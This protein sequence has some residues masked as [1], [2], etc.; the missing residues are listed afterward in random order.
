MYLLSLV[1]L[2]F[3]IQVDVISC[4]ACHALKP[5]YWLAGIR[6]PINQGPVTYGQVV[7][8]LPFGNVITI[9]QCT[10]QQV[11]DALTRSASNLGGGA[12]LQVSG[13]RFFHK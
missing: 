13:L 4:A 9:V 11:V 2:S 12:F 7:T 5:Y 8:V 1:L 3:D 6:A 10:G